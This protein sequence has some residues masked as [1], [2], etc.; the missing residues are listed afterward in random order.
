MAAIKN[1]HWEIERDEDGD[2]F[3]KLTSLGFVFYLENE[4]MR[5]LLEGVYDLLSELPEFATDSNHNEEN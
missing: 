1:E 2:Y 4:E 5:S 3:L